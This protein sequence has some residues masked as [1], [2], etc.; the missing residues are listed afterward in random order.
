MFYFKPVFE[1]TTKNST[2]QNRKPDES[3]WE[4]S[5]HLFPIFIRNQ[6]K[7]GITV[8]VYERGSRNKLFVL[9]LYMHREC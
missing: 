5:K 7:L 4:K 6:K 9:N 2:V 8:V 3:R 1:L